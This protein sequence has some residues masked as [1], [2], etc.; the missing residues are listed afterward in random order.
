MLDCKSQPSSEII[1]KR[2]L[3]SGLKAYL[4]GLLYKS[5]D[6]TSSVDKIVVPLKLSQV[7][8]MKEMEDEVIF[9][10][11]SERESD[12]NSF[13]KT[14]ISSS[15][16]ISTTLGRPDGTIGERFRDGDPCLV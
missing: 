8:T 10:E 14:W 3:A 9:N 15:R 7:Y 5:D 6:V 4:Y 13:S 16:Y 11:R 12:D 1:Q 2:L